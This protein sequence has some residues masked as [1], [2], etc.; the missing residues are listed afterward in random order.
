VDNLNLSAYLFER[1]DL[2]AG[3]PSKNPNQPMP[4]LRRLLERSGESI[5]REEL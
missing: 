3:E 5:T 2:A 4:V 1:S